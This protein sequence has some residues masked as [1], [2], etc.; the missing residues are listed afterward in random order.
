MRMDE[1]LAAIRRLVWQL[2]LDAGLQ[3]ELAEWLED[4]AEMESRAAP[5]G[6]PEFSDENVPLAATLVIEKRAGDDPWVRELGPYSPDAP[7]WNVGYE[8]PPGLAIQARGD[9]LRTRLLLEA[10][11]QREMVASQ[12]ENARS[13]R[14]IANQFLVPVEVIE[15]LDAEGF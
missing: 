9:A 3:A 12:F 5:E 2:H 7:V 10:G 11:A 14:R 8:P 15:W 6:P 13:S 1:A 4:L